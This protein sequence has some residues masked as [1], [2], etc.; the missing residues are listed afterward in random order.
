VAAAVLHLTRRVE[1]PGKRR[2]RGLVRLPATGV[3]DVELGGAR[4]RLDLAESLHRDYY[5][6]LRE[7]VELSVIRR[8]LARGGDFVDVGAHVGLYTVSA[9]LLLRDRGR[10]L[11]LEPNP[12]ARAR[13]VENIELNECTNVVIDSVA[14]NDAEEW[15]ILHVP[16]HGDGARSTLS[17]LRVGQSRA[18]RVETAALDAEVDRHSVR[19]A[20]VKIDVAGCETAVLRGAH[21]L[22]ERRPA[23]LIELVE[24][25]SGAVVHAL[26][27]LGYAVARAGTQRLERWRAQTGASNAVF[28]QPWHLALLRPSERRV[29]ARHEQHVVGEAWPAR[30]EAIERARQWPRSPDERRDRTEPFAGDAHD[31]EALAL[32]EL[33]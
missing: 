17:A 25:N 11:A 22:L 6:G 9:A 14:A 28:L 19:P 7:H 30:R 12:D 18:V 29:F 13:L 31:L 1:F 16:L 23:L 2:L 4:F 8:V 3:H 20:V 5:F 21:T 32:H 27:R 10:V 24:A 26:G 15:A 33:V